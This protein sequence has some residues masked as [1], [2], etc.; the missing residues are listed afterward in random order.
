MAD[1]KKEWLSGPNVKLKE[2]P[3]VAE[4]EEELHACGLQK[5]KK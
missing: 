1:K 3:A 5:R 2:D 4:E